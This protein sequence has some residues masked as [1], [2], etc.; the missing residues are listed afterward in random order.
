MTNPS[1]ESDHDDIVRAVCAGLRSINGD[2]PWTAVRVRAEL[3]WA[4]YVERTG[5]RWKDVEDRIS[6]AWEAGG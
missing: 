5:L 6:S 4:F 2:V 3:L 1:Y